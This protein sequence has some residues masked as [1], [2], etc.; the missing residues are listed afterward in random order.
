ML[1]RSVADFFPS[2]KPAI[3]DGRALHGPFPRSGSGD[4]FYTSFST[5]FPKIGL[6]RETT[7]N[8]EI[9]DLPLKITLGNKRAKR[10]K[11]RF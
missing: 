4:F 10:E 8:I 2:G 3:C 1:I 5:P 11:P 6:F 7:G 9:A